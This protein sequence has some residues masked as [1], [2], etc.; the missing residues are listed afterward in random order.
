MFSL[1][2]SFFPDLIFLDV[3][4][5]AGSGLEVC[6]KIN[7]DVATA[8]IKVVLITASN[9]FVNLNEGKA[10]ADHYLSRPFD[11]DEVAEL[12]RRLTS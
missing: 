7:S 3:M 8:C 4:L 1:L 6:K 5:G 2:D 9:P 10:G 12:A 11:F